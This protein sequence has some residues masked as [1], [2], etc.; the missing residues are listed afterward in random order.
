MTS[1]KLRIKKGDLVRV[2]AGN[3]KGAEGRVLR[4]IPKQRRLVVETVNIRKKHQSAQ[5]AGRGQTQ[6]GVIQF[7]APL[8]ISNVMLVC[9]NCDQPTRVGKRRDESGDGY[10]VCKKCGE[11]ID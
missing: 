3:D 2:I 7:E 8:D 10:R 11:D 1:N 9:P 4:V 6:A 5:Q